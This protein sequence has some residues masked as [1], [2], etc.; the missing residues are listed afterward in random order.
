MK[1]FSELVSVIKRLRN[2]EKGCPWDIKQ[3]S[4]SL[5]P[6]FIEEMYEAVEAI[7]SDDK[8]ALCEELGDI[9]L[10]VGMQIEIAEENGDFTLRDVLQTITNK[11]IRRHPHIFKDDCEK[12]VV[13][14]KQDWEKIKMEEKKAHR[15]SI[16]DGIPHS[17]PALIVAQRIQDKAASIGFDWDDEKPVLQKMKEEFLEFEEAYNEKNKSEI[18]KELGDIVFTVVNLARKLEIDTE[19]ALRVTIN[20]FE[21]RFKKIERYFKDNQMDIYHTN[22]EKLDEIWEEIKKYE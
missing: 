3:T 17:M 9:L 5:V 20:K 2:R 7:E 15:E 11:L 22:L 6:N 21:T 16:L 8:R 12:T 1:E 18:E 19:T 10:H 13:Q 14:I 4:K